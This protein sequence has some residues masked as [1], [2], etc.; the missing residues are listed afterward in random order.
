MKIGCAAPN[1][2]SLK[3]APCL[4]KTAQTWREKQANSSDMAC[5]SG[6][7][8]RHDNK[9]R[10]LRCV[11]AGL[12]FKPSCR[13]STFAIAARLP[14]RHAYRKSRLCAEVSLANVIVVEKLLAGA[15]LSNLAKLKNVCTV[16]N[17]KC[18]ISVL[19]NQQNG[20]SC[21]A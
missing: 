19:L 7:L 15:M 1:F 10:L 4:S 12:S 21:I 16:S 6:K 2:A 14:Q 8:L 9:T 18:H 20:G 13:N 11:G 3:T 17:L 5:F